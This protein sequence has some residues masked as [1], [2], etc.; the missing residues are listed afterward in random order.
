[1]EVE[2]LMERDRTV[3]DIDRIPVDLSTVLTREAALP[4]GDDRLRDALAVHQR[5]HEALMR[6]RQVPLKFLPPY[7]EPLT[8]LRWIEKG[9]RSDV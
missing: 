2:T 5:S 1:M 7:I 8:A 3:A 9:G 4:V 6:V